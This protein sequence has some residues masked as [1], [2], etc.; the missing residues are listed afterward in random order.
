[1]IVAIAGGARTAPSAVPALMIP[2]AVARS[3]GGNHEETTF[4]AA[5]NPPPSPTPSNRRLTARNLTLLA[6]PWLAHANDHQ[7]ITPAKPARAP[8]QSMNR[9]PPM[10]MT[11]YATRNIDCKVE[12]WVFDIGI[13]CWIAAIAT[14][15]VCRS[16]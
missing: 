10:Y 13:S 6:S 12:Y 11:A 8:T 14:G 2:I 15:S 5:G 7:I 4:V 3:S 16:K 1:M 9:P